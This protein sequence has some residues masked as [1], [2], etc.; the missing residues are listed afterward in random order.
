MVFTLYQ[1]TEA[2][3][4]TVPNIFEEELEGWFRQNTYQ[5]QGWKI[6][7]R[8]T[9]RRENIQVD[10]RVDVY[11]DG[12]LKDKTAGAGYYRMDTQE[13]TSERVYG[14]QTS[15]RGELLAMAK[16]IEECPKDKI[17]WV[18]TDSQATIDRIRRWTNRYTTGRL[19]GKKNSDLLMRIMK[20]VQLPQKQNGLRSKRM[21]GYTVTKR[22]TRLQMKEGKERAAHQL[23]RMIT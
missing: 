17:L 18:Y 9:E 4:D 1:S 22:R 19:A 11:T 20:G 12:S 16:A 2:A 7:L 14:H 3:R 23:A 8:D 10:E 13:K 6:R 21:W 15:D 5:K